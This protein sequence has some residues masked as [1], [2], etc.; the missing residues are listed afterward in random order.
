MGNVDMKTSH[1][2]SQKHFKFDRRKLK[3]GGQKNIYDANINQ[4]KTVKSMLV[5]DKVEFR[6]KNIIRDK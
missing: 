2:S 1:Y 4:R 6:A 3:V 5:S